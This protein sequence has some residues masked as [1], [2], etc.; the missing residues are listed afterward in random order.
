MPKV[1]MCEVVSDVNHLSL[2]TVQRVLNTK[3]CIDKYIYILHDKCKKND[4]TLK[5]PHY[6]VYLHF[7]NAYDINSISGWFGLQPSQVQKIH[8]KF[9]D[10]VSYATHHNAPE[11]YQYDFSECVSNFDF[12]TMIQK[13]D[14]R[15]EKEKNLSEILEGI[16]KGMIKRYNITKYVTLEKFVKFKRQI[17]DAF[18]YKLSQRALEVNRNMRVIYIWGLSGLGKTTLAKIIAH[19]L[20]YDSPFISSSSNDVFDGYNGQECIILDDLRGNSFSFS[21]LLKVLDPHTNSP[22]KRRYKNI[23]LECDILFITTVKTPNQ[24]Y[25]A[26]GNSASEEAKQFYRRVEQYIQV[27][28][29]DYKVFAY[30]P[31]N[32]NFYHV[33]TFKNPVNTLSNSQKLTKQE[34]YKRAQAMLDFT[35]ADVSAVTDVPEQVLELGDISEFIDILADETE[36]GKK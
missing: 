30:D 11:K 23:F 6:H 28:E 5:T 7:T 29:T 34:Q 14:E 2:D 22:V 35:L 3:S 16:D 10:A 12:Q 13:N 27:T 15:K 32:L 36:D 24:L 1:K 4:G 8:G 26:L 33:G 21:D 19:K 25:E 17:L 9:A 18:D 31:V 20:G